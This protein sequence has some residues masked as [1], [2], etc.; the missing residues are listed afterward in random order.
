MTVLHNPHWAEGQA[1]SLQVAVRHAESRGHEAIVV[2]IGDQPGV[3]EAT[4]RA[5]AAVAAPIVV[6][7]YGGRR[8]HP[9]RLDRSIWPLLPRD[10]DEGA[11]VLMRSRPDLVTEVACSGDPA[12]VDTVEDL[13]RWS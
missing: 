2:G 11:R 4:W 12:D 10:G 1:T 7:T 8:G 9:V 3:P 5:V 6:A 13:Q